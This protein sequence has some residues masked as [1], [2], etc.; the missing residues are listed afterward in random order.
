MHGLIRIV[1]CAGMM[2][3]GCGG[4]SS[5]SADGGTGGTG[6]FGVDLPTAESYYPQKVGNSW[7]YLV[8]P[9]ADLPS[10]KV[11]TIEAAEMVGGTGPSASRPAYRHVTCKSA[12][13]AEA[14]AMPPSA[15]NKVDRTVGWLG[16]AD[17]VVA[18][19]REQSFKKAT[20]TLVEEDWWEP[21]R[22]KIDNSPAHT[23][24]G[25]TWVDTYKEW[26]KPV[27]GITTMTAQNET[28][29]VLAVDDTVTVNPPGGAAKTYP[30]CLKV[31]HTNSSGSMA[32][33]FWY[34]KGIGKVKE[35]GTQTE[36]LI[37]YKVAP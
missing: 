11:V 10:Y 27:N 21:F 13:S 2:I 1:V 4:G 5:D 6:G 28:W 34:A 14:C 25:A 37:D 7:T 15:T 22:T 35:L 17:K 20:D 24:M 33:T 18:N 19:Y 36:E 26:K 3:S 12:P 8:T 30:H 29:T 32:K 23:T 16:W 31:S 9:A